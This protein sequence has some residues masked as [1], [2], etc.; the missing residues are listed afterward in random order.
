MARHFLGPQPIDQRVQTAVDIRKELADFYKTVPLP[1]FPT[2]GDEDKYKNDRYYANYTKG[3]PHNDLGE[4][5][6]KAYGE[7]LAAL[8]SGR[9]AEFDAIT[10][11]CT[12]K[13]AAK[14]TA[15]RI[16]PALEK[17]SGA[18][19]Q[20]RLVNPQAGLA[21]EVEGIDS[22]LLEIPAPYAF[23]SEG[24][25]GEIAE[26]YWLALVRDVPFTAYNDDEITG[27]AASDLSTYKQ[28]DGPKDPASKTVT[29]QLLFRGFT[30]G[31]RLGPY[32]SQFLLLDVPYGSQMIRPQLTYAL[33]DRDYMTDPD[34]WVA[35]QRGCIPEGDEVEQVE[36]RHIY[37]GRDLAQYVHIDEL[38]QAYLNACLL[39]IT[40]KARGGLGAPIDEGNPYNGY[41][42][43]GPKKS[44]QSGFGTL[45]EPYFKTIVTEVATRALKA[46]WFQKWFVH[47]RLRPEVYAGRV[48]FTATGKKQYDFNP[49]EFAK[50]GRTLLPQVQKKNQ[51][52][53][54]LLPMAFPEGSPLHPAYGAG[55]AT[56]AGACVT[57]LKAVFHEE[58]S[59]TKDLGVV[60]VMP[61]RDG[62][63]LRPYEGKDADQLTVGGELNKLAANIGM[64][65]NYAGVHWRSDYTASMLLGEKVALYLLQEHT[66]NTFNE[67]VFFSVTRF[68]GKKE[69]IKKGDKL[70]TF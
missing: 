49:A 19:M 38:Y 55:H 46:V 4:V 18:G 2:N 48:H 58:A 54:F 70:K 41:T 35:V 37:R 59:F 34:A 51:G 14:S 60:P 24:E 3:L 66:N 56:V 23:S 33:P 6:P 15:Q 28:F 36:P 65:R 17:I 21:F 27:A 67:D 13:Q 63:F 40:P 47:R 12:Q 29:Q 45:G 25:I 42:S 64:A 52:R 1:T 8:A 61:T 62:K 30:D 7:L 10:L 5:D 69:I 20:A 32:V 11:G 26:N 50:L 68:N 31:D 43:T 57:M 53:S 16:Y 39:L 22:H 44:T 9:P